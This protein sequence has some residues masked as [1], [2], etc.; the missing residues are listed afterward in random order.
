VANWYSG[1]ANWL[2]PWPN[3][4]RHCAPKYGLHFP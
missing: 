2:T 3:T 1:N 4:A